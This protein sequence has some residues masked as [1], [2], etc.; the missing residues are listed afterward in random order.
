LEALRDLN[1]PPAAGTPRT[2]HTYRLVVVGH[3]A[4]YE[5][6][7]TRAGALGVDAA[8][9]WQGPKAHDDAVAA[10]RMFD[11]A[12][13]PDTLTTGTPMK[14]AEYAAMGRPIVAPDLPNIRDMFVPGREIFVFE[15][16]GAG[17]LAA[18]IR[19]LSAAPEDSRRM[20]AAARARV[21]ECTWDDT[22]EF[23]VRCAADP[24]WPPQDAT[25]R[26]PVR[27]RAGSPSGR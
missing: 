19:T 14:L 21:A 15:P 9:D 3:G 13:L 7:R 18:A 20:A 1:R 16:G 24:K 26:A 25:T 5:R 17:A 10:M 6:L 12:V 8:V 4:D 22:A 2:S 27:D 11:I 23:L